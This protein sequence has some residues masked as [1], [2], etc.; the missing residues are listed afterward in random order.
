MLDRVRD[1][2]LT[3]RCGSVLSATERFTP[4]VGLPQIESF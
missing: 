4:I 1:E 2:A 3:C